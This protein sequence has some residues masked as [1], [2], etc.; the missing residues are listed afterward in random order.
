MRGCHRFHFL[1][2]LFRLCY[3]QMCQTLVVVVVVL[4]KQEE[5]E[6]EFFFRREYKNGA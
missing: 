1:C 5:E 3:N 4:C 6:E 2:D